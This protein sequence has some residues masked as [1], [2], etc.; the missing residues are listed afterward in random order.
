VIPDAQ[1]FFEGKQ[2]ELAQVIVA[3]LDRALGTGAKR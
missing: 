1:H 3:F 2:D